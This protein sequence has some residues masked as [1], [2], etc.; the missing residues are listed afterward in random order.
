[1]RPDNSKYYG[2]YRNIMAVK[3]DHDFDENDEL[4]P[5]KKQLW[6]SCNKLRGA[7]DASEYKH[8]VLPLIFL[9]YISDSYENQRSK[10]ISEN[11]DPEM[12]ERYEAVGVFWVPKGCL[13]S[14]LSKKAKS[15]DFAEELDAA[16]EKIEQSNENLSGVLKKDFDDSDFDNRKLGQLFDV[17]T[18][19]DSFGT[20]EARSKDIIGQVYE[21]F[22]GKFAYAEQKAGGEFYTPRSIVRLIVE[23][24]EPYDGSIYD[25]CCGSGGMFVQSEKFVKEREQMRDRIVYGQEFNPTTWRLARM[26][27]AIRGIEAKI[28]PFAADTMYIDHHKDE[29]FDFA[30]TNPPFNISDWEHE[31]DT[32]RWGEYGIPPKTNA[33]FAFIL[34]HLQHLLPRGFAAIVMSNGTLSTTKSTEP[35]IRAKIVDADKVD[36]IIRLPDKLFTNTPVAACIWVLA[37]SKTD[38]KYRNRSNEVL[39]MDCRNMG[40]IFNRTQRRLS[41]QEI[42]LVVSKYH[43]WRCKDQHQ[44]YEDKVGFCNSANLQSIQEHGYNLVPGRYVGAPPLVGSPTELMEKLTQDVAELGDLFAESTDL[45]NE[46]KKQLGELGIGY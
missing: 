34:H 18:N 11:R 40:K 6:K 27:L 13:W 24:L 22:L 28:G 20:D 16:M 5:F 32:E 25:G 45:E 9:K 26:N 39:F 10:I 15:E 41:N 7:M 1:M 4:L 36:C 8:F 46:L 35:D 44:L 3:S 38:P 42:E 2:L 21:Y 23:M 33:N 30:M 31:H 12:V 14:D 37:N 43:Q 19:I 17:F 29:L